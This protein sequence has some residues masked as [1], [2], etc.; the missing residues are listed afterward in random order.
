MD[1][2]FRSSFLSANANRP[3]IAAQMAEV[4]RK[5][6]RAA[7]S[8]DGPV[9]TASEQMELVQELMSRCQDGST[10]WHVFHDA[11]EEIRTNLPTD[12]HAERYVDAAERGIKYFVESSA[13]DN[14]AAGRASKRLQEFQQAMRWTEKA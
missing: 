8:D 14:A 3:F 4:I 13:T 10:W 12:K 1:S 7:S 2:N 11:I 5:L 9:H 6:M